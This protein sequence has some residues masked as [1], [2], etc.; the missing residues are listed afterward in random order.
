MNET[1]ADIDIGALVEGVTSG[2]WTLVLVVL[3]PLIIVI[4][5]MVTAAFPTRYGNK[6]VN[7]LSWGLNMVAF[8]FGRNANADDPEARKRFR[9]S[10][11]P[12]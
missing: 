12:D 6:V 3:I 5:N 8:N 10:K 2:N 11:L 7:M 4:A 9:K 1:T